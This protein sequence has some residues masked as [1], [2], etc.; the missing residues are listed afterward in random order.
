MSHAEIQKLEKIVESDPR[1]VK[2]LV[3]L[4]RY[5][6]DADPT[7]AKI[8]K[9]L[10]NAHEIDKSNPYTLFT[11]GCYYSKR[12]TFKPAVKYFLE[13]LKHQPKHP[14]A[15]Y[16]LGVCYDSL[17]DYNKSVEFYS[18]SLTLDPSK[19][20]AKANKA[21]ALDKQGKLAEARELFEEV[22]A[23][24]ENSITLNNFAVC[25]KKLHEGELA[26]KYFKQACE[27]SPEYS[28]A[29]YNLAIYLAENNEVEKSLEYYKK[30]L[31]LDKSHVFGCLA[32]A[33][34]LESQEK[35]YSALKV[36]EVIL[37]TIPDLKAVPE[38]ITLIKQRLADIKTLNVKDQPLP[39]KAHAA[40]QPSQLSQDFLAWSE[41]D[42]LDVLIQ[43]STSLPGHLRLALLLADR[44][45]YVKAKQHLN[46]VLVL[47]PDFHPE[48]VY[49]KLGEIYFKKEQD[50]NRAKEA[51]VKA[52]QAAQA[53]Q[54]GQACAEAW[55]KCGKCAE[56]L[57]SF[58]EACGFY[59]KALEV[60]SKAI[61]AL[62]R[63]G[64]TLV[65]MGQREEGIEKVEKAYKMD[66]TN[67]VIL[68]KYAE[69]LVKDGQALDKALKLLLD[70]L[71]L[72]P[73]LPD[74]HSSLGKCYGKL[75]RDDEAIAALETAL[76]FPK[77]Q[78]SAYFHLGNL[79]E[80]RD[81]GKAISLYKQCL[82]LEKTYMPALIH[83]ATLMANSGDTSKAKKY[84]REV[85]QLDAENVTAHFSLGKIHQ[86]SSEN[87]DDAVRHFEIVISLDK[88]HYKACC[89]LG[90]LYMDKADHKRALEYLL[91][92]IEI[93]QKYPLSRI[94]IAN[95]YLDKGNL[96]D[97]IK[98]F[99]EALKLSPDDI[100][101]LVGL[102]NAYFK[103]KKPG[104]SIKLYQKAL[105][106]D[107]TLSETHFNLGNSYY[108]KQETDHAIEC[109][110]RSLELNPYKAETHYNLANALTIK[111]NFTEAIQEFKLS[112]K[113]DPSNPD[114]H[115]NMG[116][117]FYFIDEYN[118]A[119]KEYKEAI[120]LGLKSPEGYFNLGLV[121]LRLEKYDQALEGFRSSHEIESN[122]YEILYYLA[123]T[124]YK[125]G[126]P[127]EA[128]ENAH[129]CLELKP[130]Y[131]KV[132]ELLQKVN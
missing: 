28:V 132:K 79:Y 25:L 128:K 92:S 93:N 74:T 65:K 42:C 109:Y 108:L 4:A 5:L 26:L 14:G 87:F 97:S 52:A 32:S 45:D 111:N 80:K 75:G 67:P 30:T 33:N 94:S 123:L 86:S 77:V 37:E 99:K 61:S 56:K 125:L 100:Q 22:L 116:N 130:D 19:L 95:V 72:K 81:K 112:V 49:D 6:Q 121:Y 39:G 70:S 102:G 119:I 51:F 98:H 12:H 62:F 83:L 7:N 13:T 82:S 60:D 48:L 78:L 41:N 2:A 114:A 38:K 71:S 85:L 103:L 129:R 101:A 104:E 3:D 96:K 122:N 91:Q 110:R 11:M 126:N 40:Q 58:K 90:I 44:G 63:L 106:I 124:H 120:Q 17:G 50:F 115:Y 127:G 16:N 21:V 24:E 9:Y 73:D 23:E 117:A 68:T 47:G 69:I 54:A 55:I 36:Y 105:N 1:N 131:D 107:P 27:M 18:L 35:F 89:Q 53:A 64:W 57:K 88:S 15:A 66:P 31:K 113:L 20:Q 118:D 10:K 76:S 46:Q 29:H 84:F 8:S 34:L 43:D 59:H